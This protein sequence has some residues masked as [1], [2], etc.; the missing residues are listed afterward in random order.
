[1]QDRNLNFLTFHPVP[2]PK[3]CH[4][5]AIVQKYISLLIG[6]PSEYGKDR[7][8]FNRYIVPKGESTWAEYQNLNRSCC[9][10]VDGS[11][12]HVSWFNK[13][14][15]F[16]QKISHR[17]RSSNGLKQ[18]QISSHWSRQTTSNGEI[19]F[20]FLSPAVNGPRPM[21]IRST[22]GLNLEPS[23][24]R[25]NLIAWSCFQTYSDNELG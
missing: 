11:R 12:W 7:R 19:V 2:P 17:R 22:S 16:P 10:R 25:Q 15:A 18:T 6:L 9:F 24:Q 3:Q 13:V 1:M 21:P 23:F 4:P 5:F 8:T 14:G 20:F